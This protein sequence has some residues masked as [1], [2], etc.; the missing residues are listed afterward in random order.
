M[1]LIRL[2]GLPTHLHTL[3][4]NEQNSLFIMILNVCVT[5]CRK[6]LLLWGSVLCRPDWRV[7]ILHELD[8]PWT[9][10]L[11]LA[12]GCNWE[13]CYMGCRCRPD[14]QCHRRLPVVRWWWL[15]ISVTMCFYANCTLLASRQNLTVTCDVF[16]ETV[17]TGGV[18][19]AARV[20]RG[21]QAIRSAK[22]VFFWL[23]ADGTYKVTNDLGTFFTLY[24]F[25]VRIKVLIHLFQQHRQH[26]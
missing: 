1:G 10:S 9:S 23:F 22:G 21:G 18:F 6:P 16:M 2:E 14:H 15:M 8:R 7:W 11:H 20:D 26:N 17:G 25:W 3:W 5:P 4:N 19:I 13:A 24:H 12:T